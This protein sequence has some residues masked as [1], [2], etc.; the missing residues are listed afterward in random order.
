LLG[1]PAL[2][3]F[4]SHALE[5]SFA[6]GVSF[7]RF[8]ADDFDPLHRDHSNYAGLPQRLKASFVPEAL[9]PSRVIIF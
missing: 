2:L 4:S 5:K 6:R 1:T 7:I 8:V 9:F 3:G